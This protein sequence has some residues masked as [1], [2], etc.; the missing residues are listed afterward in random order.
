MY[1]YGTDGRR[2]SGAAAEDAVARRPGTV[3]VEDAAVGGAFEPAVDA[4]YW[5]NM[6]GLGGSGGG[7]GGDGDGDSNSHSHSNGNG[8]GGD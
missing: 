4:S 7:G 6:L 8:G 2:P 3:I 5:A 1:I